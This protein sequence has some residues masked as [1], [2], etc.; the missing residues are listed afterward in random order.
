MKDKASF[1]ARYGP[2][3]LVA[4][5]STGI[6]EAYARQLAQRGMNVVLL[7]RGREKLETLAR[8]LRDH[9][10]AQVRPIAIDLGSEHLLDELL[11]QV[12]DLEIGLLIYNAG[13]SEVREFTQ[14]PLEDLLAIFNVNCRGPLLLCHAL[15]PGMVRRGRGGV[16]LMSSMAGLQGSGLV[17]DYAA[18]KAFD[19][20]LGEGLWEEWRHH[21]VHVLSVVAGA[22]L[23]P[24]VMHRINQE[25][26]KR[27]PAMLPDD[28]A[29]EALDALDKGPRR[30]IGTFNKLGA[31][32]LERLL[33][34]RLRVRMITRETRRLF[35][36]PD[37]GA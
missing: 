13:N 23:T 20:V 4:G 1:L 2:W 11:P 8:E 35:V 28:V 9:Y 31:V 22:T 29:R 24:T 17:A 14:A 18:T 12:D 16:I 6:G 3:A 5:A 25:E 15:G 27:S 30:V 36:K 10:A 34:R 21:G 7:A 33:S 37:Q 32:L 19:I 26:L